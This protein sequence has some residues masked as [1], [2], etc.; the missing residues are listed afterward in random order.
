[1]S[2]FFR[3]PAVE[4]VRYYIKLKKVEVWNKVDPVYKVNRTQNPNNPTTTTPLHDSNCSV[5]SQ[6]WRRSQYKA[7]RP[8]HY[9]WQKPP[10]SNPTKQ[11]GATYPPPILEELASGRQDPTEPEEDVAG[12]HRRRSTLRPECPSSGGDQVQPQWRPLE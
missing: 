2:V 10:E 5:S 8:R 11:L 1:M 6:Q 12:K 9:Q 7:L 3:E 4:H